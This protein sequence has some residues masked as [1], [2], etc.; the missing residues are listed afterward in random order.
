MRA[1]KSQISNPGGVLKLMGKSGPQL[2]GIACRCLAGGAETKV[3]AWTIFGR[4]SERKRFDGSAISEDDL[5]RVVNGVN[6][7]EQRPGFRLG[8]ISCDHHSSGLV[9]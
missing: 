5:I 3:G 1:D 9:E 6:C 7:M 2:F 4:Q 8:R